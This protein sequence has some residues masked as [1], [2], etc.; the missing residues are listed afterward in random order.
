M[1][2]LTEVKLPLDHPE[3]AI[4]AALLARLGIAAADLVGFSVFR[5]AVDA[6]KRSS[7]VLIYTLDLELRNEAA[8]LKRLKGDRHVSVAPDMDYRF[9]AHAPPYSG[10]PFLFRRCAASGG[11]PHRPRSRCKGCRRRNGQYIACSS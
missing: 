2:R 9:V 11:V 10:R 6:R 8:V 3:S 7:I 5:R 4:E 1:L